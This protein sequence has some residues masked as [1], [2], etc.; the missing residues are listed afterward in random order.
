VRW[1]G[2][3]LAASPSDFGRGDLGSIIAR[4]PAQI[5]AWLTSIAL[6]QLAFALGP[7]AAASP[8]APLRDAV[9]RVAQ[10]PRVHALGPHRAALLRC[11]GAT[12]DDASALLAIASRALAPH[13][14][15]DPL[16]RLQI[17]RRLPHPDG[18]IVEREL[19]A[20]AATGLD[21]VPSWTALIA[22]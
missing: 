9:T 3:A 12:L 22:Q 16:T 17:T 14:A 18:I 5:L 15:T 7:A 19:V 10:P 20:G 4:E 6:D 2:A 1:T 8:S 21:Q 11:R 13:L